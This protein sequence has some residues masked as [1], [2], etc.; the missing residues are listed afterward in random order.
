MKIIIHLLH[1]YNLSLDN[2][3]DTANVAKVFRSLVH[4][5]DLLLTGWRE[6]LECKSGA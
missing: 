6:L 5:H 1:M 2:F 4:V 3:C